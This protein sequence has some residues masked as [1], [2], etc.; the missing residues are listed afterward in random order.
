LEKCKKRLTELY[1]D[2][3]DDH[4]KLKDHFVSLKYY[5]IWALLISHRQ[6]WNEIKK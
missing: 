4:V 1:G 3:W 2:D 6:Q 5:Y